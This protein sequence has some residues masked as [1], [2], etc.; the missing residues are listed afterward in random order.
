MER[1]ACDRLVFQR[2][3]VQGAVPVAELGVARFLAPVLEDGEP[4]G[5]YLGQDVLRVAT[6]SAL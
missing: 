5:G 2:G 1:C 3:S 6:P 4:G